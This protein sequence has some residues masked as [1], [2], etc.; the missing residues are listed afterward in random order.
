MEV[1]PSVYGNR[2]PPIF[3]LTSTRTIKNYPPAIAISPVATAANPT[4]TT[5]HSEIQNGPIYATGRSGK[6][7]SV[8]S[9]IRQS[10]M[11]DIQQ[12]TDLTSALSRSGEVLKAQ[13]FNVILRHFGKS[14]R[15]KDISQLFDWM[16]HYGKTNIASYSSYMKFM[17]RRLNPL[18][19]LEIY[20]SI[21]DKSI[22]NSVSICNSV[23]N[24]LVK[25]GKFDS[26]L[27]LFN[28]MKQD[29]LMP[30][31]VTYSTLLVGCAKVKDGYTKAL[32]LVQEIK[33]SGLHLDSIT[34]GTL[35]SV[36]ASNNRCEEAENYFEQIKSEGHAPNVFH[37]SSLLNAYAID[38]NYRKA[39]ELIREMKSAGVELN[40]VILTTLLKVY[41]KGG[42]FDRSRE[43]LVEL[44]RL[45]YAGDEMPYCL[46]MDGLAK[47]GKLKE[48]R[49]VFDE[50]KQNE[51]RNDGYSYS[52]M[53]SALCRSGFLEDAKQLACEFEA[54]YDKYDVVI[55]NTMLCAYCRTGEMENVMKM[56]KKMD[57]SAISPDWNTFHIL[58]KYFSKEKLYLLAFRTMEDMHRKGHEPEEDLCSSLIYYLGKTGAHTE[59][60]SVYNMLRYSKKTTCK[61][62][63]EKILHILVAGGL[64]KDAYV[65]VKDNAKFLSRAALR[66]F[67]TSFMKRGNMNLINDVLKSIHGSGYK[68]DQEIFHMA[69]SRYIQQPDKNALLLHLLQWMPGQG[70]AVDSSTRSLILKHSHLFGRE[71]IMEL[72]SKQYMVLKTNKSREGKTK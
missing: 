28:Q 18:T 9:T 22:R 69:I 37:Y 53:I 23:L 11:L 25:S 38:G 50:M 57:E 36:C 41:V 60:F 17:G 31:I 61:A 3:C 43:L 34:Y 24:C 72:L 6:S 51:V 70:Y 20:N 30:D 10:A 54:K 21:K 71:L 4:S 67:S 8:S 35:I 65:V 47:S 62:L 56:M 7:L 27:K 32:E 55:L 33:S 42:L 39:D 26:S 2:F 63:H 52:I 66:K 48:A 46:L 49:L 1:V 59:A 15:W 58:I 68:I 19:V 45:G 5:T 64:L 12:S 40:K 16:Q 44:Q 13:D 14:N 29:G